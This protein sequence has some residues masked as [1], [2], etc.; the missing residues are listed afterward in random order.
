MEFKRSC[1]SIRHAFGYKGQVL[2]GG[3]KQIMVVN[4]RNIAKGE[5]RFAVLDPQ[6]MRRSGTLVFDVL[7]ANYASSLSLTVEEA[8]V[9]GSPV[10]R[11]QTDAA[12][13]STVNNSL[14][15]GEPRRLSVNDWVQLLHQR[16]DGARLSRD[17]GEIRPGL[18]YGDTNFDGSI[19]AGDG[20]YLINVSLAINEMIIGTDGTGPL[21]DRDAVVAGN[22]FPF[23]PP[24]GVEADGSRIVSLR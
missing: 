12:L 24:V 13:T 4:D 2:D 23:G 14:A 20:V 17:P 19:T 7:A 22:V 5:V 15:V 11:V 18:K 3:A 10:R 6:G 9:N 1:A 16:G 21:G 8:A